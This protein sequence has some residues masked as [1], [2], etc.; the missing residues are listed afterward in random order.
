M[1]Q[2]EVTAGLDLGDRYSHLCLIAT[3]SGEVIS[4]A[5]QLHYLSRKPSN[6]RDTP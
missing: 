2:L 3:H 1:S 4:P 5:T 6:P